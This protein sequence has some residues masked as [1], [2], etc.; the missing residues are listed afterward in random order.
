MYPFTFVVQRLGLRQFTLA[1]NDGLE[2]GMTEILIAGAG[3][4]GSLFGGILAEAG[5]SVTL[6]TRRRD[7]VEAVRRMDP[8]PRGEHQPQRRDSGNQ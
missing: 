8:D 6:F 5:H 7:H 3:A 1:R 2:A 4:L